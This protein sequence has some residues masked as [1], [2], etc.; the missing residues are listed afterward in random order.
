MDLPANPFKAALRAGRR[1]IGCWISLADPTA[2]EIAAT[3][4]FDWLVIDGEHAPND[5]RTTLAQLRTLAAYPAHPV[6]RL[7]AGEVW[8]I[9]QALDIG[10][11]TLLIPMV[12][13]ADQARALV[14]AMRYAPQGVRGMGGAGARATRYGA[15]TDYVQT[16]AR[17]LCLLVQ[18]ETR[19]GLA[20]LDDILGVEGVD[21]V[22]IG[23]ADLSADMGFP[24]RADA[25]EVR[26]AIA[27][28]LGR[29]AASDKA[30]GILTFDHAWGR[31]CLADGAQFLAVGMDAVVLARGMRAL[32]ATY[33]D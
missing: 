27:G 25:P 19:A 2:A 18:V 4:G 22:F 17:E 8:M 16:A 24:G 9:K 33:C 20:A 29:I 11:Q 12:E 1:Q 26:A 7:P 13:S 28:A 30:G 3:A 10:A 14:R 5:L 15:V 23:P 21:G 32:A 31:Q 6:V